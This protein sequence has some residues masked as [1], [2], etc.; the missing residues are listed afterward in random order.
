MST[1]SSIIILLTY[2][3]KIMSLD[4]E[5]RF[6]ISSRWHIKMPWFGGCHRYSLS[7]ELALV[8]LGIPRHVRECGVLREKL[9]ETETLHKTSPV[10]HLSHNTSLPL[11]TLNP[12]SPYLLTNTSLSLSVIPQSAHPRVF[13]KLISSSCAIYDRD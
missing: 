7:P 8:A 5:F 12:P 10:L 11:S 4:V 6:A 1:L 3:E 2:V 13:D 9:L